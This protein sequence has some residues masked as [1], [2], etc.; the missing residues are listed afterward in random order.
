MKHRWLIL[1]LLLATLVGC[2][3]TMVEEINKARSEREEVIV[4]I[5]KDYFFIAGGKLEEFPNLFD[6]HSDWDQRTK[7]ARLVLHSL[8]KDEDVPPG[9]LHKMAM[10]LT[11]MLSE[12]RMGEQDGN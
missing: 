7:Q 3:S 1:A 2:R 10:Y 9:S 5:A 11:L 6:V 12:A 8:S 4:K